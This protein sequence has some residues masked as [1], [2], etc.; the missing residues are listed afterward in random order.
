MSS[1]L[2]AIEQGVAGITLNLATMR[3]SFELMEHT[4]GNMSQDVNHMSQPM[5]MF[6]WLNPLR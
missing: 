5:R 3:G 4:V 6:N 1:A 2:S